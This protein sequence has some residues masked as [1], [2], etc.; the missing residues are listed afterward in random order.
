MVS[1]KVLTNHEHFIAF[2]NSQVME[3]I[4]FNKKK[5]KNGRCIMG[6]KKRLIRARAQLQFILEN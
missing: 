2:I 3:I 5:K 6:Y 1:V 4:S